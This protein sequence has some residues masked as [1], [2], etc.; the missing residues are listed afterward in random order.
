MLKFARLFAAVVGI[1]FVVMATPVVA[2]EDEY[3]CQTCENCHPGIPCYQCA[4]YAAH[5]ISSCCGSQGGWA[6][7]VSNEWGFIGQ[8]SGGGL[9]Q[10]DD[11]GGQCAEFVPE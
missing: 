6:F 7:C 4:V 10:C 9:C 1:A 5:T 8:C 2:Q 11:E 3:G